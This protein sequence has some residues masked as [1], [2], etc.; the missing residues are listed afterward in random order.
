MNAR[1]KTSLLF[2]FI[3]LH[4]IALLALPEGTVS[5]QGGGSVDVTGKSMTV[6]AP[7]GSIFE[8]QSFN[9][10]VDESVQFN[11]PTTQSRVLNR[12][13]TATPSMI[14]GRVFA[15][16]ELYLVNPA[17]IIFGKGAVIEAARLHAIAGVLSNTD[18]IDGSDAF[19]ALEAPVE[20]EGI[21]NAGHITLAGSKV[22]NAGTLNASAGKVVL[23]AAGSM[24]MTSKDGFL[25]VSVSPDSIAPIGAA[26]DLIG[27]TLLNSGVVRS[28]EAHLSGNT[29]TNTGTIES[30][31]AFL[32]YFSSLSAQNGTFSASEISVLGSS[33]NQPGQDPSGLPDA[34]INSSGNQISTIR[35]TGAFDR[36]SV[37]SSLSA[38]V[39]EVAPDLSLGFVSIGQADFRSTGGDLS[40][41]VTFSPVFSHQSPSLLLAAK[42]DLNFKDPIRN[43]SSSHQLLLY[44]KNLDESSFS[45]IENAP[46]N[47]YSLDARSLSVADLSI[48]LDGDSVFKLS[49]DNPATPAFSMPVGQPLAIAQVSP[50]ATNGSDPPTDPPQNSPPALVPTGAGSSSPSG[51]PSIDPSAN[52]SPH[53][54]N[55]SGPLSLDQLKIAMANGL[56]SEY[57]YHLKS[58]SSE[59]LSLSQS[60]SAQAYSSV[61]GDTYA[62]TRPPPFPPFEDPMPTGNFREDS[63]STL[64]LEEEQPYGE[65]DERKSG[66]VPFSTISTPVPSSDAS[67]ILQK[68]LEPA[69]ESKLR[70]FLDR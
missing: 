62:L 26:T 54:P 56:F 5:V 3:L 35:A 53:L 46:A 65:D 47:L 66:A 16:G 28:T 36:M 59:D 12:I 42:G 1:K 20:N 52:S 24:S 4:E 63:N 18:F 34:F 51:Q 49:A 38:S 40:V 60:L 27:Q 67:A 33:V 45:A 41:E 31:K 50:Q 61:F 21:I 8:H 69:V 68:A 64:V 9:V 37:S 44:G 2:L 55:S 25:T 23:S 11:Q 14:E 58:A 29:I 48:G 17:G 6:E 32:S 22:A 13:T 57:S 7:D 39:A 43:P 70:N 30:E 15:N 10:A 19:T